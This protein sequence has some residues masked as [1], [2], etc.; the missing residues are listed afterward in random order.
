MRFLANNQPATTSSGSV[1]ASRYKNTRNSTRRYSA[2]SNCCADCS[3]SASLRRSRWVLWRASSAACC[4]ASIATPAA[5]SLAF[6]PSSARVRATS[7]GSCSESCVARRVASQ[8]VKV[9]RAAAE[10][11]WAALRLSWACSSA[12]SASSSA[13]SVVLMLMRSASA[14]A[15][16]MKSSTVC[17]FSTCGKSPTSVPP[18]PI[19]KLA[20]TSATSHR[21]RCIHFSVNRKLLLMG[22]SVWGQKEIRPCHF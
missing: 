14:A 18:R 5:R 7:S 2:S 3:I 22:N 15:L 11:D 8:L 13:R 21:P 16:S 1:S 17:C 10:S 4:C 6:R 20:N 19:K 12:A 9:S